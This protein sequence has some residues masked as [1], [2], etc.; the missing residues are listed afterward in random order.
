MINHSTTQ[1]ND[2]YV[3]TCGLRWDTQEDDPHPSTPEEHIAAMREK[4]SREKRLTEC[5]QCDKKVDYLFQDSRC[6][7]CTRITPSEMI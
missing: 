6:K 5:Y 1:E 2:E 4:L 3:C 7:D